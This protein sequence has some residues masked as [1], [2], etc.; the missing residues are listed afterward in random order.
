MV[1]LNL[2]GRIRQKLPVETSPARCWAPVWRKANFREVPL[3]KHCV[4]GQLFCSAAI[5]LK[6]TGSAANVAATD[7]V[8]V[9]FGR[10]KK[11]ATTFFKPGK[12]NS[13]TLNSEM[14]AKWRW[15]LGEM[16]AQTREMAVIS[17]MWSVESWKTRPSQKWRKCLMAALAANNSRSKVE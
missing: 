13:C 17:G 4:S 6:S 14:N 2:R 9:W 11:S 8:V 15:C 1:F 5:S 12:Y 7:P 16:G 10:D 3:S